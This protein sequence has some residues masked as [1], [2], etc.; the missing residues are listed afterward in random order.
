L[1]RNSALR[2]EL[3]SWVTSKARDGSLVSK[4]AIRAAGRRPGDFQVAIGDEGLERKLGQGMGASVILNERGDAV[5][6]LFSAQNYRGLVIKVAPG[7]ETTIPDGA[8][9]FVSTRTAV[10]CMSRD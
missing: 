9:D 8:L 2:S 10:M 4:N 5:A 7:T 6:V 1:A 3:E